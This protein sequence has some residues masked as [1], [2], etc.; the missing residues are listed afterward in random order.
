MC[1]FGIGT[2]TDGSIMFPADRNVV[3]GIKLT[4]GL[5]STLGVIPE[6]LSIDTAEPFGRSVEDATTI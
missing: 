6:A 5:T 4:V 2:E 3:V 1:A